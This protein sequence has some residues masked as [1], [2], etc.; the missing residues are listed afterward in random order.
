MTDHMIPL[1]P[2][3]EHTVELCPVTLE[4]DDKGN[5]I[6]VQEKVQIILTGGGRIPG[7]SKCV[8]C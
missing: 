4:L 8:L 1:S 7:K 6:I 2:L 3:N 5:P